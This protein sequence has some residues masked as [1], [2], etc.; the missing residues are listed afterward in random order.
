MA[1]GDAVTFEVQPEF[2]K[3]FDKKVSFFKDIFGSKK[4]FV[5]F[6]PQGP[7]WVSIFWNMPSGEKCQKVDP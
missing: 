4:K 1:I 7:F 2:K 6:G 3:C 5:E